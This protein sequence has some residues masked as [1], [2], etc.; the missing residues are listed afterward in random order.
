LLDNAY[1]ANNP[2]TEVPE[3]HATETTLD[4]LL[5][6]RPG[7]IV[8][9]KLLGGLS[10]IEHPD[11]GGH[12]MVLFGASVVGVIVL[13]EHRRRT[14]PKGHLSSTTPFL[15]LG[16]IAVL[17]GIVLF[18]SVFRDEPGKSRPRNRGVTAVDRLDFNMQGVDRSFRAAVSVTRR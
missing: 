10:V 2:R 5:V 11:I 3:S 4:D 18:L 1:L 6:S 9:T 14:D 12:A 15:F 16:A 17:V 8:R 7:G 13:I